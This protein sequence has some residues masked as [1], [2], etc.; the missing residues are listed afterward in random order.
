MFNSKHKKM[1]LTEGE[2]VSRRQA[3]KNSFI[4]L[5]GVKKNTEEHKL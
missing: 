1:S 3:I 4:A 2:R 5:T